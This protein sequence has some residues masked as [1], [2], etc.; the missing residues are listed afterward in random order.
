MIKTIPM[1]L[2]LGL[3]ILS[4]QI[5]Y[6]TQ[7]KNK[8]TL[9]KDNNIDKTPTFA[10][11]GYEYGLRARMTCDPSTEVVAASNVTGGRVQAYAS[12]VAVPV[13]GLG[14]EG[15][16]VFGAVTNASE[17]T[18][19]VGGQFF[20]RASGPGSGTPTA[21]RVRCWGINTLIEDGSPL[22]GPPY[23]GYANVYLTH[24]FDANIFDSSTVLIMMSIGGN[25]DTQP[26]TAYGY[27]VNTLSLDSVGSVKWDCGFCTLDA[28]T[29]IGAQ[30]GTQNTGNN[31]SSQEINFY[32]RSSGG[33][34][35]RGGMYI[36]PNGGFS[37][38]S[39]TLNSEVIYAFDPSGG[40]TLEAGT[41]TSA[42]LAGSGTEFACL[43]S[44]GS[45]LRSAVTCDMI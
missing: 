16:A 31:T 42:S 1:L 18:N 38:F 15:V 17:A 28:T 36:D 33:V 34:T 23:T 44:S 13:G 30:F 41:F 32:A 5:D 12:C 22:G 8:P 43:N 4:Q 24:E 2:L 45:I 3:P 21:D 9:T 35:K 29:N 40:L 19:A 14:I 37:L 27:T 25:G 6:M 20:C 11:T 26:T 10:A 7:L 39:G